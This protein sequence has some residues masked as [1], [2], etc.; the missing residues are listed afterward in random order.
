MVAKT[1]SALFVNRMTKDIQILEV[2]KELYEKLCSF[3]R[4]FPSNEL[5]MGVEEA[6]YAFSHILFEDE[7]YQV[8]DKE[9]FTYLVQILQ[10]I[11][12]VESNGKTMLF[13][14]PIVSIK[15]SI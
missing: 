13:F 2:K 9:H 15:D 12:Q 6:I 5:C 7:L 14:V 4:K 8:N 11:P 3:K 1:V 10:R